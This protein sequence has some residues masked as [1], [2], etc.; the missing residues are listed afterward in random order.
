MEL[1]EKISTSLRTSAHTG[2]AI[3]WIEGRTNWAAGRSRGLPRACG[4]RNDVFFFRALDTEEFLPAGD[5]VLG[6]GG[7]G[8]A[9]WGRSG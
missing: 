6:L 2:V 7:G 9:A 3:P 1:R 8:A 4:P 5:E